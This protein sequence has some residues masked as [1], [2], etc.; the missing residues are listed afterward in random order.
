LSSARIA[1]AQNPS[2]ES[3]DLLIRNTA[4]EES[5]PRLRFRMRVRLIERVAARVTGEL[6]FQSGLAELIP[7][8]IWAVPEWS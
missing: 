1:V 8:T 7:P 3:F 2:R 6:V 4:S 5:H